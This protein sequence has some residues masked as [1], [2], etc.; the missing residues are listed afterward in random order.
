ML[1]E[2]QRQG[3]GRD[4]QGGAKRHKR[5]EAL[6]KRDVNKDGFVKEWPEVGL[7]AMGSPEDPEPSIK[8]ENGIIV[9]MDGRTR[10]DFDF[11]EIFIANR[12]IDATVAEEMMA[13]D[14]VQI[15]RMLVDINVSRAEVLKV[16]TGLTPAKIAAVMDRMNV[17]EMMM[18]LQKMRARRTPAIQGHVTNVQDNPVLMA[19]DAGEAGLYG[20]SELETTVGVTRYAPFNALAL[21]VGGQTGRGGILTQDALEEATELQLGMRGLTS[22]AETVS[23]YG[24]EAVFVD[25][26]DTPW[27]KTFLASGYASRDLKMRFTS[28]TGSEVQMASAE[29]KSM[30]YLEIKCVMI[31]KGAGVQGLQNGSI[32]CI[33]VPGGVPG[34]IRAVLA[35]NLVTTCMDMEV[36]S[37]NDQSFSHSPYRRTARTLLQML[38]GTDFIFSGYSTVPNYDNMFAGSNFDCDDN[39]DYLIISRDMKVDG[40]LVPTSEEDLIAVRNKAARALQAV[41]AE[42]GLPRITDEEVE[43]ATYAHGSKD[44]PDRDKVQDTKAA[45]AM[46]ERGVTGLDVVKALAKRGFR[47]VATNVLEMQKQRVSGD[48]LHTSAILDPEFNV[49]AAVNDL[50]DYEGPGTGYRLQ[51]ERWQQIA[52]IRQAL[53]PDDI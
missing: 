11:N 10:D 40:G 53:G 3:S 36:A 1:S 24:T 6:E 16:F 26:D 29:G 42:L 28:G 39:D 19:A 18:A 33:A 31:A 27:S 37:G 41:F 47:D 20:F 15:A 22:Y 2:G 21:L 12:T 45:T 38:P 44:M 7:I 49:I 43:A 30:L 4:G 14:A 9:E 48:Y 46:M 34:G 5:F 32:S 51:G 17:V 25:G 13:L 35:E 23:V 52:D 8:I 50:N